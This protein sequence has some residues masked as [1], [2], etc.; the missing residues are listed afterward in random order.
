MGAIVGALLMT[1]GVA[2]MV[3][4]GVGVARLPDVFQGIDRGDTLAGVLEREDAPLEGRTAV[5]VPR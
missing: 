3:I 5:S 1:A 2:F 4:A